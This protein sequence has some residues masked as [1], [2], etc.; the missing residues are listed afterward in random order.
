MR[1]N[2]LSITCI[3]ASALLAF[4]GC[5]NS[6]ENRQQMSRPTWIGDAIFYQ[7]FPERFAN[8]DTSNDPTRESLEYG[9]VPET[10]ELRSWTGDWYERSEWEKEIGPHFYHNGS[11]HRRYG[12]DLQ[13]VIDRLDYLQDLGINA[14]Y[15]NPLFYARSLHKYDGNSYHH[16]DPYFGPDPDGDFAIMATETSDPA[17]WSWTAADSLFLNLL[18]D[19]RTRGIRIVID[20]V[21]NHVGRDFFA[22]EDLR[23]NQEASPYKDWFIVEQFDDPSTDANEFKYKG[24]WGVESLPEFADNE[25]GTDLHEGPKKYVYD[26]TRRWMDPDGDGDP[27]DGVAGWR[28]DVVPDMPIGFWT[29]WNA[30]VRTINP[31][32]YTTSE[33]WFDAV[34]IIVDG[35]FSS[36]MNYYAFAFPA[37][38]FLIDGSIS[39]GQFDTMLRERREAYPPSVDIKSL[40]NLMD[41]HDTPRLSTAIHN[42]QTTYEQP[43]KFDYDVMVDPRVNPDYKLGKPDS[44]AFRIQRMVA[45]FQM[46]YIGAPMIYYGTEAGMWGADDPDVRMP[47]VWPELTYDDQS[48]H[49]DGLVEG[50]DPLAFDTNLFNYYR[51]LIHFRRDN[52]AVRTGGISTV[53]IDDEEMVY[54][55]KRSVG[56]N[57]FVIVLNRNTEQSTISFD[58]PTEWTG[59]DLAI[60]M[61][62]AEGAAAEIQDE[63]VVVHLEPLSG[64]ILSQ[65]HD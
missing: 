24:W 30:Y 19:A 63:K 2:S 32:V 20:G 37:K 13:G 26:S 3:V 59:T 25:D 34:D 5:D 28:L 56:D 51:D 57:A 62:S 17:T 11:Y 41:S 18:A 53:G 22:F 21:W 31:D 10:W 49:P 12:G 7:I 35:G 58:M 27:S 38:G 29:D 9:D 45:M 33:V 54:A 44:V 43:D 47:M 52:E 39:P 8:G 65:S 55:F 64:M 23:K 48:R 16:I 42:R 15:F 40:L 14:I 4:S 61:Q 60:E 50:K 46:T 1:C 36:T 6:V